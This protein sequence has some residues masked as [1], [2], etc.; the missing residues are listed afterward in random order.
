MSD[1]GYS[2]KVSLA[3]L[4]RR[5]QGLVPGSLD[6]GAV[7]NYDFRSTKVTREASCSLPVTSAHGLLHGHLRLCAGWCQG[8]CRL[9]DD[10][11]HG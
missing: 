2:Q 7:S 6:P 4:V 11:G 9:L 8:S 5:G 3:P 10:R 1:R